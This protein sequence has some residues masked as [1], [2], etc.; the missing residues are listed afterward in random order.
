MLIETL[1]YTALNCQEAEALMLRITKN[2]SVP[3]AVKI[4]LVETV[5]EATEIECIWDAN[6]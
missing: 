3:P 1:L 4:E 5:R 6:D 2:E